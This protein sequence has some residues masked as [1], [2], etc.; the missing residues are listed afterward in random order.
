M[1]VPSV[2][3]ALAITFAF[4]MFF[5]IGVPAITGWVTGQK[6]AHLVV[7]LVVTQ[8]EFPSIMMGAPIPG[9]LI[10]MYMGLVVLAILLY[11][12]ITEDSLAR[13]FNPIKNLLVADRRSALAGPKWAVVS[14]I[15]F[16]AAFMAYDASRWHSEPPTELRTVHPT[17]PGKY[18][19][20]TNPFPWS[21]ENVKKGRELYVANCSWCHGDR[22]DGKG[23]V[24]GGFNPAPIDF[25]AAGTIDMLPE[26]YIFWRIKEGGI[27]LPNESWPWAS[28]MPPWNPEGKPMGLDIPTEHRLS[29]DDIWLAVMGAYS[30][31]GR[32]PAKR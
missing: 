16:L 22:A 12:S 19:D 7:N 20:M 3:W 27:G 25:A 8:L 31:A 23:P 32:Q 26:N 9:S 5:Q 17:L 1:G 4:W 2:I 15:S 21:E 18:L 10:K 24:A 14:G 30:I 11:N 29:D 13:F 28:A 6:T